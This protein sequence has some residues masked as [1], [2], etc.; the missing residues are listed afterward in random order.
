[1]LT[2][3][4]PNQK[5]STQ[6]LHADRLCLLPDQLG[7]YLSVY[8]PLFLFS[9]L[10]LLIS[11]V[12]RVRTGR[13]R[14][15]A[16]PSFSMPQDVELT[17][18][19]SNRPR[20]QARSRTEDGSRAPSPANGSELDSDGPRDSFVEK[21]PPRNSSGNQPRSRFLSILGSGRHGQHGRRGFIIGLLR[22]IRD[23]AILPVV[24]FLF[25]SWCFLRNT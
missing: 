22:D 19:S 2:L 21:A 11:N 4:P 10:V 17:Y 12:L 7:I 9:L 25:I 6:R 5:L 13:Y 20:L 1:M 8:L 23:V 3:L 24:L 14:H 15:R 18:T 16:K